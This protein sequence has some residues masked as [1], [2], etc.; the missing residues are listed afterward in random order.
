[1]KTTALDKPFR[2]TVDFWAAFMLLAIPTLWLSKPWAWDLPM[3]SKIAGIIFLPFAAV[4]ICYCPVLFALAVFCGGEKERKIAR[5][6]IAAI[7]GTTAFLCVVWATYGFGRLP[8]LIGIPAAFIASAIYS[9][10]K[11]HAMSQEPKRHNILALLFMFVAS[12]LLAYYV[13]SRLAFFTVAASHVMDIPEPASRWLP[14][15]FWASFLIPLAWI[16]SVGASVIE[17]KTRRSYRR[18]AIYLAAPFG[19]AVLY[20]ILWQVYLASLH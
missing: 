7:A 1:M 6:F 18:I 2:P 14:R 13:Q 16:L 12:G 20:F 5:A 9:H 3:I 15:F 11:T 8:S 17:I 19:L 4:I 10:N